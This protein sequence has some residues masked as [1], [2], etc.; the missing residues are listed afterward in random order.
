ME[1][2]KASCAVILII[3]SVILAFCQALTIDDV[4]SGVLVYIA[5]AFMLAGALFGLDVYV[6]KLREKYGKD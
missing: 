6:E 5:Q 3:T 4:A 1:S 2:V